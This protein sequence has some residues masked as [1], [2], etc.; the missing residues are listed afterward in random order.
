MKTVSF[1]EGRNYARSADHFSTFPNRTSLLELERLHLSAKAERLF[2][3]SA[4]EG[5][6]TKRK[7]LNDL[8]GAFSHACCAASMSALQAKQQVLHFSLLNPVKLFQIE[9]HVGAKHGTISSANEG[10]D[11]HVPC[12]PCQRAER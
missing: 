1:R 7:F 9:L 5:C 8:S 12:L 10:L 6:K 11:H 4:A 2:Q 3:L